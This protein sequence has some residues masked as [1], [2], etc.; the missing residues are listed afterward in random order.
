VS[1]GR[2]FPPDGSSAT[3]TYSLEG[4][5]RGEL[6]LGAAFVSH[7]NQSTAQFWE[8]ADGTRMGVNL[9]FGSRAGSATFVAS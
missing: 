4:P 3:C 8:L 2:L 7:G 9:T 6:N 5:D 1:R